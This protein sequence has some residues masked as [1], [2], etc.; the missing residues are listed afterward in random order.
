MSGI[1]PRLK[2]GLWLTAGLSLATLGLIIQRNH[3]Q[4]LAVFLD[5]SPLYL[6]MALL[7]VVVSWVMRA[8]RLK[9]IT[10]AL[11]YQVSVYNLLQIF[12]AS[13]FAGGVTPF[14]S[15]T[16]PT[17]IYLLNRQGI[18]LGKATA[19]AA[20]DAACTSLIYLLL[21][22]VLFHLT[23]LSGTWGTWAAVIPTL[24]ILFFLGA[25][26]VLT[27]NGKDPDLLPWVNRHPSLARLLMKSG[28][29]GKIAAFSEELRHLKK[30]VRA[31]VRSGF[32]SLFC[33]L[34][35]T[36]AYWVTFLVITP[37][38]LMALRQV[39][40]C[41]SVILR[42]MVVQFLLP[43]IPTL[44]GSGGAEVLS[45]W[46][47]REQI[48]GAALSAFILLW[49]SCTFYSAMIGGGI[50]LASLLSGRRRS[51]ACHR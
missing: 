45:Y 1:N 9:V 15:G 46:L 12:L 49:R 22:P 38:I 43:M 28:R 26:V 5:A 16:F 4:I 41:G 3:T 25:L 6:G 13:S 51:N 30:G 2:R 17:M 40:S 31:I 7:A 37:L 48:S 19:T 39:F 20:V 47:F 33:L 35:S 10:N 42:Q 32:W 21:P 50:M 36:I 23:G 34:L 27:V 24:A 18:S 29:E 14:S 44:G 8:L 11:D